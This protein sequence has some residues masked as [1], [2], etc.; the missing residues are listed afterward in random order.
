M[1]VKGFL[2]KYFKVE[3]TT[4]SKVVPEPTS[5]FE[6]FP[7]QQYATVVPMSDR[8]M[9]SMDFYKAIPAHTVKKT[10]HL[11]T[12]GACSDNGK[13]SAKGGYGVHV[14]GMPHLDVSLP[15]LANEGQTNNRAE[16]KAIQTAL[17]L[18]DRFD[19]E[20]SKEYEDF[21]IWSDSEYSIHCL[22]KWGKGW[23]SNNWKKRDGGPIQNIDLIKS[24]YERLSRMHRVSLHHVRGHQD[25]KRDQFPYDGNFKADRLATQAIK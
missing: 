13:K 12:D 7:R 9:E 4:S 23:K 17:D 1:S 18:I 3:A 22:T 5:I 24:N 2:E 10:L 6:P 21:S 15:L 25:S 8:H 14:Y 20:W 19:M 16:L 11:F